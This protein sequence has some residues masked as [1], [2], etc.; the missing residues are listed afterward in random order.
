MGVVEVASRDIS[1]A[2]GL[3]WTRHR[4]GKVLLAS[5][6]PDTAKGISSEIGLIPF[7]REVET[8]LEVGIIAVWE[9]VLMD[10]SENHVVG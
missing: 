8:V 7:F 5:S 2:Y 10:R 9:G 1:R 6:R 3:R 4:V